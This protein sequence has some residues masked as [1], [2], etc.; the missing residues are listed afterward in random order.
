M[1]LLAR[2][3]PTRGWRLFVPLAQ[4]IAVIAVGEAGVQ[5]EAARQIEQQRAL[6]TAHVASARAR[7]ESELNA[8]LFLSSGLVAFASAKGNLIDGANAG[9]LLSAL[10]KSGRNVRN[11]VIAP[12]NRVQWVHPLAGNEKVIGLY[13]P[14]NPKQWPAVKR[15]MERRQTVVAGPVDLVQGGRGLVS[16]TP[17]FDS[18]GK[19]WGLMSLVVDWEGLQRT[20]GLEASTDEFVLAIRGKDAAGEAGEVFFG[21]ARVFA[22]EPV[23]A[24]LD[25]PGGH[26][27]LAAAPRQGWGASAASII[28][29]RTAY[30]L[31]ALVIGSLAYRLMRETRQR[32]QAS[33]ELA[34]LNQEL[35]SRIAARTEQLSHTRDELERLVNTLRQTQG[36]LVRSEKLAALGSLVAGIAHELNTPVG[37]SLLAASTLGEMLRRL[38]RP[39]EALKRSEWQDALSQMKEASAIIQRSLSRAGELVASFKQVASDRTSEQRRRFSL[40]RTL[41]ELIVTMQPSLRRAGVV[42]ELGAI[43]EVELDSYPGPFDQV[44]MNLIQNAVL[45]AY[46][47]GGPGTVKISATLD[48]AEVS[49]DV[50]DFGRGIPAANLGKVFDPF[51][52]TRLGMGGTGLGLHIVHN[53]VVG[54]LGGRIDVRSVEGEGTSFTLRLPRVAPTQAEP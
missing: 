29:L 37:N 31:I 20:A 13:Y 35:E 4:V 50:T 26:W 19:Y 51:F 9:D 22:A 40:A 12:D 24:R 41:H 45:H 18:H 47:P 7:L 44:L 2:L 34:R 23:R 1:A 27:V 54:V 52:T 16:R 48:G 11:I 42:V 15:A 39:G 3:R 21:D 36:D 25:L 17:V 53:I 5:L 6:V 10:Y 32:E 43:P 8:T 46:A 38:D 30:L 33:A 14:D 28:G 49:L